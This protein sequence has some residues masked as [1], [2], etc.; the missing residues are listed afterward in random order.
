MMQAVAERV[1]QAMERVQLAIDARHAEE[2]ERRRIGRELHD[3]PRNR[4]CCSA[5]N[6][7]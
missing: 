7:R 3:E 6:W 2:Q 5:C 4:C 1:A